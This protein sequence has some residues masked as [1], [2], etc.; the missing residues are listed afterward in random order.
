MYCE[1][2]QKP[3]VFYKFNTLEKSVKFGTSPILVQTGQLIPGTTS[4][5]NSSGYGLTLFNYFST[6]HLTVRDYFIRQM[7]PGS[8]YPHFIDYLPCHT[9]VWSSMQVKADTV[10]RDNSRQCSVPPPSTNDCFIEIK[11]ESGE[12]I[13]RTEGKCPITY[14]VQCGICPDG[15]IECSCGC[16]LSCGSIR[17]E[18]AAI[19]SILRSK[20]G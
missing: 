6:L 10:V 7:P 2:N 12:R 19:R 5:F 8:F 1:T 13:F 18:I 11:N 4:N 16:C 17:S 3:T 15:S 20:H 14:N 9:N